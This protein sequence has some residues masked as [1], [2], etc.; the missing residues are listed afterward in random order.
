MV[1][2][3][4]KTIEDQIQEF[5]EYHGNKSFH[6][7]GG[8][9]EYPDTPKEKYTPRKIVKG[10]IR[11]TRCKLCNQP[12]SELQK[13]EPKRRLRKY[14]S[15]ECRKEHDEIEKIRKKLGAETIRWPPQKPPIRKEQLIYTVRG[16]NGK[17]HEYK[18]RKVVKTTRK[19]Y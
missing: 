19:S 17:P 8:W 10:P 18:A 2:N 3:T 15:D 16:E 9:T 13:N 11:W 14:C 6:I 7:T 1:N 12:L 4:E 5:K